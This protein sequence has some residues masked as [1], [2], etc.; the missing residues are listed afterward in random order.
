MI[1]HVKNNNVKVMGHQITKNSDPE[2]PQPHEANPVIVP[3]LTLFPLTRY[4]EG[5]EIGKQ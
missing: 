4:F 5:E 2:E 1:K 3:A